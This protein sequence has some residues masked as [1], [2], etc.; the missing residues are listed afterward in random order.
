MRIASAAPMAD[1]IKREKAFVSGE[2]FGSSA[3]TIMMMI[4]VKLAKRNVTLM[5]KIE[6]SITVIS[7]LSVNAGMV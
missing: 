5:L 4:A 1:S 3:P 2:M 6:V 7:T